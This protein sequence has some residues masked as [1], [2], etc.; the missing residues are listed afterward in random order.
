MV[1]G[2][3]ASDRLGADISRRTSSVKIH[4]ALPMLISLLARLIPRRRV[5]ITCEQAA[6]LLGGSSSTVVL[7]RSAA[8]AFPSCDRH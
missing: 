8:N 5:S 3:Q 6:S 1:L 7:Q 4:W 2:G